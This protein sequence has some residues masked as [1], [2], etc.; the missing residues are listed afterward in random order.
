VNGAELRLSGTVGPSDATSRCR[1]SDARAAEE[2]HEPAAPTGGVAR[3]ATFAF[4]LRGGLGR[5]AETVARRSIVVAMGAPHHRAR[6]AQESG[7]TMTEDAA[8]ARPYNDELL[9]VAGRTAERSLALQLI[10]SL[11]KG[12]C[13]PVEQAIF[14]F[15]ELGLDVEVDLEQV[16]F[17][18]TAGLRLLAGLRRG[19]DAHP[20]VRLVKPSAAVHR[21]VA[22]AGMSASLGI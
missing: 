13:E 8:Q 15:R 18:D 12:D 3:P 10:G 22:L 9:I 2:Q 11:A 21:V 1:R 14:A 17:V 6:A 19:G 16:D 7:R 4:Q 20:R 5:D